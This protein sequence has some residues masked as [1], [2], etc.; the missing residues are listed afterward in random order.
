MPSELTKDCAIIGEGIFLNG[1]AMKGEKPLDESTYEG[2]CQ[3]ALLYRIKPD[4]DQPTGYSGVAL[5]AD[6]VREDGTFGP[7]VV[8]F[9]SFVQRTQAG[10]MFNLEGSKLESRLKAGMVAFY[11][12]FPVPEDLRKT[13]R[14]V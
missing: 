6:G 4:F 9:Q 8:G 2:L 10:Q 1:K 11:G 13:W 3:R 14:I 7:G 12:A 5:Y